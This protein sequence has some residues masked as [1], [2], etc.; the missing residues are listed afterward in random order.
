MNEHLTPPSREQYPSVYFDIATEVTLHNGNG[1]L[2]GHTI[3]GDFCMQQT[4]TEE[5]PD[6]R[7]LLMYHS[8]EPTVLAHVLLHIAEGYSRDER[9]ALVDAI[10]EREAAIV[11]GEMRYPHRNPDESID[12]QYDKSRTE[13]GAVID[14]SMEIGTLSLYHETPELHGH[15]YHHDDGILITDERFDDDAEWPDVDDDEIEDDAI[16]FP[17]K[18]FE[19]I[20]LSNEDLPA[21]AAALIATA[22]TDYGRVKHADMI[23][24][25][26]SLGE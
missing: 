14:Q 13:L 18:E 19:I 4:P 6:T 2:L 10:L 25:L 9:Q 15:M 20:S 3:L 5:T 23:A 17:K 16:E 26:R 1:L 24:T 11:V 22:R 21:F 8:Q 7:T 12:R